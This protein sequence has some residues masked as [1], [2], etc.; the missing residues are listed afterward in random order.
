MQPQRYPVNNKDICI[1]TG[2]PGPQRKTDI[3]THSVGLPL[4]NR[5]CKNLPAISTKSPQL[6]RVYA[7]QQR[8]ASKTEGHVQAQSQMTREHG[9]HP[10]YQ[11]S[12]MKDPCLWNSRMENNQ[13]PL[14]F[15]GVVSPSIG[16]QLRKVSGGP[17]SM[18]TVTS[19]CLALCHACVCCFTCLRCFC[20]SKLSICDEQSHLM[21]SNSPVH[22]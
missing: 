18:A 17:I 1:R 11:T 7:F 3:C 15:F 14:W 13:I 8:I 9:R 20:N 2:E 5:P 16:E 21:I 4:R 12:C 10:C 19:L 6:S 22:M